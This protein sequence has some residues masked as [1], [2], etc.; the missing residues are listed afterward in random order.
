MPV[1]VN[2]YKMIGMHK[3]GINTLPIFQAY[4]HFIDGKVIDLFLITRQQPPLFRIY[5]ETISP[6]F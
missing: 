3:I 2:Q 6:L 1:A 4:F 5:L